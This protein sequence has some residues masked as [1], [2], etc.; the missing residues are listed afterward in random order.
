[1]GVGPVALSQVAVALTGTNFDGSNVPAN[2]F[3]YYPSVPQYFTFALSRSFDNGLT[4]GGIF[5][6]GEINKTYSA[7]SSNPKLP[8]VDPGRWIVPLD[9]V[10]ANG[11][12]MTGGSNL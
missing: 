11:Q 2:I 3:A 4:N 7:I 8:V 10:I 9:G 1:M 12:N 5:T 6:I